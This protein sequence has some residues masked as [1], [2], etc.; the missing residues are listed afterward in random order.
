MLPALPDA[1]KA[2]CYFEAMAGDNLIFWAET[3]QGNYA[4]SIN[5]KDM[6]LID[7]GAGWQ[8]VERPDTGAFSIDTAYTPGKLVRSNTLVNDESYLMLSVRP[9]DDRARPLGQGAPFYP[10]DGTPSTL[11][12]LAKQVMSGIRVM[13]QE[14]YFLEAARVE[15]VAGNHYQVYLVRDPLGSPVFNSVAD[16]IATVDGATIIEAGEIPIPVGTEFDIVSIVNEPNATPVTFQADYNYTKPNNAGAPGSGVIIHPTRAA[17]LFQISKTD[18]GG[19]DLSIELEALT[20]G[21]I[22]N[23]AGLSWAI[24]AIKTLII[25]I[26]TVNCITKT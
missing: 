17:D 3:T 21:D 16:F 12:V 20:V 18:N 5:I 9:N 14:P 15:T 1:E 8:Q 24:Q 7:I 11:P 22:I 19:G 4:I 23:G 25:K 10:Y 26:S 2:N 6:K 13:G